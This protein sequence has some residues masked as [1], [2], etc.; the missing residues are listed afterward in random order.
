MMIPGDDPPAGRSAPVLAKS[1]VEARVA[2][3]AEGVGLGSEPPRSASGWPP[4]SA[5]AVARWRSSR[6]R[7][8]LTA[9]F[10][11]GERKPARRRQIGRRAV[12]GEFGDDA[13]ERPAAQRLLHRP[14]HVDRARHPQHEEARG[15]KSEQVEA[16]TVGAAALPRREIGC[17][18]E[19]LAARAAR[20]RGERDGKA[21]GRG[22]MDRRRG[23]ESR[24][25]RPRQARRRA[26]ASIGAAQGPAGAR[27]RRSP[28]ARLG[29]I[30]ASVWRRRF[31]VGEGA[32][33]PIGILYMFLFCSYG[34][35]IPRPMSSNLS[36][37]CPGL[38]FRA[39]AISQPRPKEVVSRGTTSPFPHLSFDMR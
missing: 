4:R 9:A 17:D 30:P 33:M 15:C 8:D 6:P 36:A 24:A 38:N 37:T 16:G 34:F 2:E 29:S 19:H 20:Q 25:A 18:P 21:A 39:P 1:E 11:R 5:T 27:R 35:P 22:Q 26:R 13:G 23:S 10:A 32:A 28:G 31:S 12:A 7:P 3:P 14:E